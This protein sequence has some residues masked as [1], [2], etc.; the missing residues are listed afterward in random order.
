MTEDIFDRVE[1]YEQFHEILS[2]FNKL[3]IEIEKL[4]EISRGR[5]WAKIQFKVKTPNGIFDLKNME[6]AS[7]RDIP[8]HK[9][10]IRII[11]DGE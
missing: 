10:I 7:E 5:E 3:M 6:I 9:E 4:D 2:T 1:G 8:S 11:F